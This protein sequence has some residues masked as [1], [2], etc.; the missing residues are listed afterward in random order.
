MPKKS[1]NPAPEATTNPAPVHEAQ[2]QTHEVPAIA[3][4]GDPPAAPPPEVSAAASA[5]GRRARGVPK[6]LTDERR[7]E[8]REA[9]ARARGVRATNRA[10][11]KAQA[12]DPAPA[13]V[14]DPKPQPPTTG[15]RVGRVPVALPVPVAR[16]VPGQGRRVGVIVAPTKSEVDVFGSG[17]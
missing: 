7:E 11:A 16:P 8:L 3:P 2:P 1:E 14:A 15:R 4:A 17:R 13:P 10:A 12:A 5:L 9:A 6:T